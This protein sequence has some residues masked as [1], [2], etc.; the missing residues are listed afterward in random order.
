MDNLVILAFISLVAFFI[1]GAGV[2]IYSDTTT[3]TVRYEQC[4]AADKQWVEGSC[5]K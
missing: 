1:G 3:E 5:V 2:L 4:I